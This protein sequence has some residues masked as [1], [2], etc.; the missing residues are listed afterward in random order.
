MDIPHQ[1]RY[2]LEQARAARLAGNEGRARVCARRAA[3]IAARDFL[4]RNRVPL[5]SHS[6]LDALHALAQF[7]DLPP[8]LLTAAIH[9]TVRVTEEFTLPGNADLIAD[10]RFL[11]EKLLPN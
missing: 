3:G 8:D 5:R 11:C 6:A 4:A 7:P 10:A 2:E 9:L 1:I